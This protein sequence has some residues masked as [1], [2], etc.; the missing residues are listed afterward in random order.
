MMKKMKEGENVNEFT[1][2]VMSYVN[3]IRIFG[4][5]LLKTFVVEKILLRLPEHFE[6]KISSI[7]ESKRHNGYQAY[8]LDKWA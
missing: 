1:D 6:A 7:E 8:K 3:K 4:D 2:R 5:A